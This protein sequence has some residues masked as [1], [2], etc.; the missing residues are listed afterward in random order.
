MKPESC[1]LSAYLDGELSPAERRQVE[2]HL[3]GCPEC[4]EKMKELRRQG[5]VLGRAG[6]GLLLHVGVAKRVAEELPSERRSMVMVRTHGVRRRLALTGFGVALAFAVGSF[7]LPSSR[8]VFSGLSN[9]VRA[10]FF[11]NWAIM[12]AAGS[13]LVWPE[14]V[15]SLEARFWAFMRGG[16]AQ[17]SARERMMVQGVGLVFLCLSAVFHFVVISGRLPIF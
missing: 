7:L 16:T 1:R 11:L 8:A 3:A 10:A 6:G 9:P 15:A 4:A 2:E 14:K 13:L 12:I 17:V 5:D